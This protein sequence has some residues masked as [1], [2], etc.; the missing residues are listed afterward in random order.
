MANDFDPFIQRLLSRAAAY[1][2][3]SDSMK[4]LMARVGSDI[5][6]R[7][8]NNLRTQRVVDT[9][10]LL[11]AMGFRIEARDKA[12]SVVAGPFNVRYAALQEF[13][14]HYTPQMFRAMFA[15]LKNRGILGKR[16][17]K[18]ILQNGNLPARPYLVPAFREST[19]NFAQQIR[20][21]TRATNG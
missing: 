15:S 6:N 4:R 1:S 12:I 8:R 2:A 20:D 11:N 16:P 13:G 9:G 5:V 10:R 14:G 18:G 21:F 17:G 19:A 7:A 3:D